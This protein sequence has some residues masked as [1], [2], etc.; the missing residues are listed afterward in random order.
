PTSSV[1]GNQY[2]NP[3][4]I[5]RGHRAG[6]RCGRSERRG[7]SLLPPSNSGVTGRHLQFLPAGKPRVEFMPKT[8]LRFTKAPALIH[9]ASVHA[10]R[11]VHKAGKGIL[12]LHS[13]VR[14]FLEVLAHAVIVALDL[15]LY[16]LQFL[17]VRVPHRAPMAA[18]PCQALLTVTN[19]TRQFGD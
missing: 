17:A 7:P 19:A 9:A 8:N 15:A 10:R 18:Q 3:G 1:M 4:F 2:P 5:S 16:L 14:E 11:E 12:E 13:Q 6:I